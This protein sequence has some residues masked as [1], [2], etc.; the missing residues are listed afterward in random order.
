MAGIDSDTALIMD[1]DATPFDDASTSN[2]KGNAS[3]T[4]V[5][6][7]TTNKV[8]GAGSASFNGSSYFTYADDADWDYFSATNTDRTVDCR[9]KLGNTTQ[10]CQLFGQAESANDEWFTYYT[11]NVVGILMDSGGANV[12]N[13]NGTLNDTN[14]HHVAWIKVQNEYGIYLDGTQIAYLQDNDTDTFA[15]PFAVGQRR[16]GLND[17]SFT[18]N[19]DELRYQKSNYFEASPNVGLTDTITVPTEAYSEAGGATGILTPRGYWGDI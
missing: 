19:I 1:L 18:G 6:L 15:A 11:P 16:G 8:F 13:F 9:L 7:D 12:I 17:L 5:T 10:T 4:G 14:W 3:N 2:N